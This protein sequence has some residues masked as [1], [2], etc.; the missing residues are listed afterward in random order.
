MLAI[1]LSST[2][3]QTIRTTLA[4]QDCTLN[5]YQKSTGLFVDLD[6]AGV[7]LVSGTV[8]RDRAKLVRHGYLGFAGDLVFV[9]TQGFDDPKS[10]GLGGRWQLVYLEA[11]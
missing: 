10:S 6:L 9:D 4:Q 7:R 2:P 1:P 3:S 5:I 8:A 11:T